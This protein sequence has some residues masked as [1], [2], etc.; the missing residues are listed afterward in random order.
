MEHK[1]VRQRW[2]EEY[3]PNCRPGKTLHPWQETGVAFL[4]LCNEQWGF[5]LLADTMGVGKV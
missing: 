2:Q 1:W 4:H 5:C 3:E